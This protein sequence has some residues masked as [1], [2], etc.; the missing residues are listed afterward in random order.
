M[1]AAYRWR[2]IC[3]FGEFDGNGVGDSRQ[4]KAVVVDRASIGTGNLPLPLPAGTLQTSLVTVK[5]VK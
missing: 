4:I 1:A 2:A 5:R 3:H